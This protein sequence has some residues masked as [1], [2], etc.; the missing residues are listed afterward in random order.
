MV[1]VIS[2]RSVPPTRTDASRRAA[3]YVVALLWGAPLLAF[4]AA[5][6]RADATPCLATDGLPCN[7][8]GTLVALGVLTA[9][10][11]IPVG[12]VALLVVA[13]LARPGARPVAV[14]AI[15][16]GVG[17]AVGL[18]AVAVGYLILS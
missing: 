13:L 5:A 1:T 16:S 15:A 10:L 3:L 11:L 7:E 12:L 2:A 17:L 14:A 4:T 8:Q 9:V 18:L 6:I